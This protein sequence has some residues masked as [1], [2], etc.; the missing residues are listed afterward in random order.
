MRVINKK[1]EEDWEPLEKLFIKHMVLRLR[2]CEDDLEETNMF[3]DKC[4]VD[5]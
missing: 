5:L 2:R 4:L 1:S 3:T